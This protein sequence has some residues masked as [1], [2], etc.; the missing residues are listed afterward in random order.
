MARD[1]LLFRK[2]LGVVQLLDIV[3]RDHRGFPVVVGEKHCRG[4]IDH[5]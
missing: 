4:R 2:E 5:V 1:E 3:H